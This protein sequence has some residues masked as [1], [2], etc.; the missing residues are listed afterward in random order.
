MDTEKRILEAAREV[1]LERGVDGARM[2]EIARRAGVNKA[3]LHYYFGSKQDLCLR[4]LREALRELLQR[5]FEASDPNRPFRQALQHFVSEYVGFVAQNHQLTQLV[6]WELR[7]RGTD[8]ARTFRDCLEQAGWTENPLVA[9]FRR[10]MERGEI[11]PVDPVQAALSL[12]AT[13][14]FPFLARDMAPITLGAGDFLDP[15]FLEKR[16][17]HIVELF[18][19]G[20]G[21]GPRCQA[22]ESQDLG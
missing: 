21:A 5:A 6:L 1:L 9:L 16:K 7:R 2:E 22:R 8:L 15:E 18:C 10:A 12:A 20:L 19:E 17:Q 13:C 14:I 3:L 4:V 11:R